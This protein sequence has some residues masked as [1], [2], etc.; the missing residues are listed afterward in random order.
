M[1]AVSNGYKKCSQRHKVR[2]IAVGLFFVGFNAFASVA[3]IVP[4]SAQYL[5]N[6]DFVKRQGSY[7]FVL[8]EVLLGLL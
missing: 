2:S 7:L 6:I 3:E 8:S 5:F 1:P 4:N